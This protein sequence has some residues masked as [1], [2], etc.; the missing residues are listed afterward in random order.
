MASIVLNPNDCGLYSNINLGPS[1]FRARTR[2]ELQKGWDIQHEAF[3]KTF[4]K[5]N[6][7]PYAIFMH[8]GKIPFFDNPKTLVNEKTKNTIDK[9]GLRIY[10]CDT[11]ST[12]IEG[13][14]TD[15]M[16][17][18]YEKEKESLV[19]S[20]EL[21]S[22][23]AYV[24]RNELTNVTV[25]VPNFGAEHL[26]GEQ[27][28][29]FNIACSPAGWVYPATIDIDVDIDQRTEEIKKHFWCGNWRYASHRHLIASYLTDK[30]YDTTNLSW[31]YKSS[32]DIIKDNIWFNIEEL[33]EYK[34]N[35]LNGANKL[36]KIAPITMGLTLDKTLETY[37]IP[38]FIH[39]DTNPINEYRESFCAI[40]NETRFAE[41]TSLLTEKIMNAILNY[42][43]FIMVG[44]PGNLKYMKRWGFMTYSE[45]W[46]ESYDEETCHYKRM[47]KIFKLIDSIASMTVDELKE[48]HKNMNSTLLYNYYHILNLQED[49]LEE[50]IAKNKTFKKI[51]YAD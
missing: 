9:K 30:H 26:F 3:L 7:S 49:L 40:V 33:G 13:N 4:F 23:D 34:N 19:R 38:P 32:D 24:T 50:P 25:Y 20:K 11:L 2:T 35:I 36:G 28:P 43:P 14:E 16:Y 17:V 6:N 41:S 29:N 10:L 51:R 45:F 5:N 12:Y 46:D 18:E 37:E 48:L 1:W 15:S 44:P 8:V 21:D 39:I 31:I 42:R 47:C 22:I 27:Y